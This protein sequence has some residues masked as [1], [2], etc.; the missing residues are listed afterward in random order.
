VQQCRGVDELDHRRQL[1][2]TRSR[3]AAGAGRQQHHRR[4]HAFA[5]GRNN[6]LSHLAHQ[7]N[8]R[9]KATANH[10]VDGIHVGG[11]RGVQACN[12]HGG[13]CRQGKGAMLGGA[14]SAVN[15]GGKVKL[16]CVHS[17]PVPGKHGT[18][19]S[20]PG[21]GQR[22]SRILM[23]PAQS[24][25]PFDFPVILPTQRFLHTNSSAPGAQ[26]TFQ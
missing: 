13:H 10:R 7:Y 6:V 1:V 15:A 26:S 21:V 24:H 11:N 18:G 17:A 23:L 9:V 3:I 16:H 19:D 5:A 22:I 25:L 14:S 2:V 8:L 12:I 4:P 20:R